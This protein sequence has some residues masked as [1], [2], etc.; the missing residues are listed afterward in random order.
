MYS[1]NIIEP[2]KSKMRRMGPAM[3][4]LMHSDQLLKLMEKR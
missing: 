2:W 1:P 3:D 4:T